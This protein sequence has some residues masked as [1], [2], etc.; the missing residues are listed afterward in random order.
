MTGKAI[1]VGH[2]TPGRWHLILYASHGQSSKSRL[3][4]RTETREGLTV[5]LLYPIATPNE[6]E[7]DRF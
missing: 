3:L 4:R 1:A 6:F 5:R 7:N 2:S